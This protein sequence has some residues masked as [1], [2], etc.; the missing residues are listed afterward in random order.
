MAVTTRPKIPVELIAR[1]RSL[2]PEGMTPS[3]QAIRRR[4]EEKARTRP[5]ILA[6]IRKLRQD[7]PPVTA[8]EVEVWRR[9]GRL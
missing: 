5:E 1:L 8:A 4:L 2:F 7:L 6:R 9:S 3:E